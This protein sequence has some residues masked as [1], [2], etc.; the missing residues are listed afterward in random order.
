MKSSKIWKWV[1]FVLNT[2]P[3]A[4]N[5]ETSRE[6]VRHSESG[7][8]YKGSSIPSPTDGLLRLLFVFKTSIMVCLIF[9]FL[10]CHCFTEPKWLPKELSPPLPTYWL[11]FVICGYI[12]SWWFVIHGGLWKASQP[13][14]TVSVHNATWTS[15]WVACEADEYMAKGETAIATE[16][17]NVPLQL[18]G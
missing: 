18:A 7:E 8:I 12:E 9:P 16:G 4:K 1:Y 15:P 2:S 6:P 3:W 13:Q 14:L 11:V 10:K 5:K 17:K